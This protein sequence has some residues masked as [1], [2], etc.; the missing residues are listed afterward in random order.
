MKLADRTVEIHSRGLENSNQF[1]IAQ[2]SK[3]FKILSDSLYSDKV[4]AVIRELS[5]NAYDAH[6]SSGNKNPFKVILPTRANPSFTI[7]DYGTGLS[8]KDMEELY[9]TYGASN[10]N[11]SN[12]FVGCLGLG[13]KSPFAYTKS[14]STTSYYNGSK[15]SYIAAMDE[16]GVPTLNLFDI[17]PTS[18]PNG[19]EISFAVKQYDFDEFSTKSKRIFHYFK[20][21]PIIEG[22]TD[23]TLNDHSY[24]Y[25]NVVIEGQGWKIGRVSNHGYQY[26]SSYNGPGSGVVAVMGN[27]AYPVDAAKIIGEENENTSN[28]NILRWNKAFKKVDVDNWKTLVKEILSS[29]LYLE[30]TFGI[31]ELEMDVSREGLQYTKNVIR[32]LREKT[33]EIYMQLK[34]DMTKKLSECKNLVEAYTTYYNLS[35]LAGGWTAGAVWV[36]SAGKTHDLNSGKDLEYKFAK[37]KQLYVFNWRSAGYRSR[38]L[39]YLTDKIHWETLSS[40]GSYYYD[41]SKKN[42]KMVFFRCDV[43]GIES[44]KKIVTKYCNNNDCFAYLMVDTDTPE[45]STEGFDDLIK[46][47]GGESSLLNVSDYKSLVTSAPRQSRGSAGSISKDEVFIIRDLGSDKNC[48][49]LGGNGMNDSAYLR[50][51]SDDLVE[52]LEDENNEI[53]YVPILRYGSIEGYPEIQSICDLAQNKDIV[54]GEKLFDNQKIF[55]IKSSSISKLKSEG[56]NLV[57]FNEWFTKWT[58]KIVSKLSNKVASYSKIMDYAKDQFNL[59]DSTYSNAGSRFYYGAQFSDRNIMFHIINLFGL[60]YRKYIKNT[61]LNDTID[62]WFMIEFFAESIHNTDGR[63]AKSKK[64]DYYAHIATILSKYNING[65]D[66]AN[67]RNAH[68][69]LMNIRHSIIKLYS[70]DNNIVSQS[71]EKDDEKS[72][73]IAGL[74]KIDNIRKN[75]KEAVDNSP[76]FKYI[77]GSNHNANYSQLSSNNPLKIFDTGGYYNKPAW[78][79]TMGD[80]NNIESFRTTLGDLI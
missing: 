6:I 35:D 42:G 56:F 25:N 61:K 23:S 41:S 53:I 59:T 75:L 67:I 48:K 28:E 45:D 50:E 65:I 29:G 80:E 31:G 47:I 11:D 3:M 62:G 34:E 70:D 32:V 66:P 58:T 76:M 54:I 38:R 33:L 63:F 60:D 37:N 79:V 14:F 43:K 20:M 10:K 64:E 18:E 77:I 46:H 27:I 22:S 8:Q 72:M 24:S 36:D 9:T 55:A 21:K 1:T 4:M 73:D 69:S 57:S 26:P 40:R 78:F 17:S 51:L 49:T 15:Y 52:Y 16:T 74:P 2:T 30:I 7:R 44:A 71:L 19:L 5:T 13:S 39:V 12:D 68:Q